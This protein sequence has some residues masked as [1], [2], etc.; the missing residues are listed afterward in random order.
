[1]LVKNGLPAGIVCPCPVDVVRSLCGIDTLCRW[2]IKK[3][4]L[5]HR[6]L[7]LANDYH[8][9]V[10]R[11]WVDTFPP[12]DILVFC[13]APTTSN[14]VMSP[15][16]FKEFTLPYQKELH[17]KI[18]EMGIRHIIVHVCGDQE[19][20]LP[21]WAQIP[22]GDPGILS[23]GHEVSLAKAIEY[24]GDAAIIAGNIAPAV[25]QTGSPGQV[26]EL[27][28]QAIAAG[29]NARR[30]FI[31]M[32]GCALPPAAPPYNLFVMKKAADDFGR[33]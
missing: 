23:F 8:L 31:L 18:L 9:K 25:I 2:L 28:R 15:R 11:Y 12:A 19:M 29:K 27:C 17:E 33:Y 1:L 26:Y 10:I 30:G 3:P 7:R 5:V 22:M 24:F 21:F 20:N 6:L 4:H 16:H 32:P 13:P 14:Q